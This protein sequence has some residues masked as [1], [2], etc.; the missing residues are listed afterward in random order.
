MILRKPPRCHEQI[1]RRTKAADVVP[2]WSRIFYSRSWVFFASD[3]IEI[4]ILYNEKKKLTQYN[5]IIV[6]TRL[7]RKRPSLIKSDKKSTDPPFPD[8][9]NRNIHRNKLK[10]KGK[11]EEGKLLLKAWLAESIKLFIEDQAFLWSYDSAPLPSPP[12]LLSASCLSYCGGGGVLGEGLGEEPNHKTA[13][14]TVP[15]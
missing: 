4:Q 1:V 12:P 14:K 15:L 3:F 7:L 10:Q 11:I 6:R 13:K 2:V 9:R 5:N 8:S